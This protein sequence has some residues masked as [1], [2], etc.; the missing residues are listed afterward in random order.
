MGR[1][2]PPRAAPRAEGWGWAGGFRREAGPGLPLALPLEI[3]PS[4]ETLGIQQACL[5]GVVRGGLLR[6]C[7]PSNSQPPRAG[8]KACVS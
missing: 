5:E 7:G 8:I 3:Q 2:R 1:P 4:V 6:G